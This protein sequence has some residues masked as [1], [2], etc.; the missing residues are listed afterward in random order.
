MKKTLLALLLTN[1][2]YASGLFSVGHKNFGFTVGQDSA[3]GNEYTVMGV[4]FSYFV[5]DNIST[6]LTYY[7]WLGSE[8]SINQFTIPVTYHLPL[9]LPFRPY[10]GGFYSRTSVGENSAGFDYDDY[11]S[12]G[13]RVGATMQTSPNSYVSFG[14]VQE[15]TESGDDSSTR[16][17]P[18][19]SGGISF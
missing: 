2:I 3:Y 7:T 14:W 1:S 15:V 12:Y 4:N 16:G 17:Y 13:A 6:G 19:I 8:P 10:L 11:N 18:E 5:V 9:K